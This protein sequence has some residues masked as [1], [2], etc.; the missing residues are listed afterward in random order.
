MKTSNSVITDMVLSVIN[1]GNGSSCGVNYN[2]R[3]THKI[4]SKIK[5]EVHGYKLDKFTQAYIEC[6]L[7]TEE[8]EDSGEETRKWNIYNLSKEALEKMIKDC[9]DFQENNKSI[10]DEA[11]YKASWTNEVMAGHDFWLTRNRHGSGFWDRGLGRIGN[12]LTEQSHGYGE[13][14]LYL[15]DDGRIYIF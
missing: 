10:L 4:R 2:N 9:K 11:N 13:C 5:M 6:A 8:P 14:S 7:W 1:D 15:G 12:L 3:Y